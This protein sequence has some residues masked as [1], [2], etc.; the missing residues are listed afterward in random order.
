[1]GINDVYMLPHSLLEDIDIYIKN[2]DINSADIMSLIKKRYKAKIDFTKKDLI[3]YLEE[4]REELNAP[5]LDEA[6][7]VPL[8]RKSDTEM[9]NTKDESLDKSEVVDVRNR[10]RLLESFKEKIM[11]R[12]RLVENQQ[13]IGNKTEIDPYLES[14]LINYLKLATD[15]VEKEV[16]LQL[17]VEESSK[18]DK[19]VDERINH[20]LFLI[21]KIVKKYLKDKEFKKLSGEVEELFKSYGIKIDGKVK[22]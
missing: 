21:A 8:P 14:I 16:K 20:V 11:D 10:A 13:K 12:M 15:I 6:N 5:T 17:E 2:P 3:K 18:L 19:M 7:L 4:R 22:G 1:M 9:N